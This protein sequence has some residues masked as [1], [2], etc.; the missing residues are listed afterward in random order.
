L[1]AL[2]DVKL[3][4]KI[5]F[6]K[7]LLRRPLYLRRLARLERRCL[8]M[9]VGETEGEFTR[10]LETQLAKV[11][12]LREEVIATNRII[13]GFLVHLGAYAVLKVLLALAFGLKSPITIAFDVVWTLWNFRAQLRA[14]LARM[15]RIG[16]LERAAT[17]FNFVSS[18][19]PQRIADEELGD[20]LENINARANAGRPAW[21][22]EL[23]VWMTVLWAV[24]HS[25]EDTVVRI[26]RIWK[27]L[28]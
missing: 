14:R 16:S 6:N 19:L 7:E 1:S 18:V 8:N 11:R 4:L 3:G 26:A 24:V 28:S 13:F 9:L 10:E 27:G 22:I 15:G 12:C 5:V 17:V 20:A 2:R 23:K 25:V 21:E